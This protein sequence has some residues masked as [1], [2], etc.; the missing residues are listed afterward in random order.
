MYLKKHTNYSF[1]L[2]AQR[3]NENSMSQSQAN[4]LSVLSVCSAVVIKI[5]QPQTFNC[6]QDYWISASFSISLV[7]EAISSFPRFLSA[8]SAPSFTA[9]KVPNPIKTLVGS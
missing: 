7:L 2:C 4:F 8:S 6:N 5:T 1:R 3:T 9:K